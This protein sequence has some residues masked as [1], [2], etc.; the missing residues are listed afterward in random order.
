MEVK[1][2]KKFRAW[3]APKKYGTYLKQEGP[4]SYIEYVEN[5]APS[6]TEEL[7]KI[8]EQMTIAEK[9]V[10][11]AI[12]ELPLMEKK[13]AV[14]KI[15]NHLGEHPATVRMKYDCVRGVI[16]RLEKLDTLRKVAA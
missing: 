12:V 9:K 11:D 16:E 8:R 6:M 3:D 7:W 2:C 14:R 10:F 5:N 13:E 4:P 1:Y 15:A